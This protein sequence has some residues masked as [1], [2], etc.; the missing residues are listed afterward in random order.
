MKK[1]QKFEFQCYQLQAGLI[2]GSSQQNKKLKTSLSGD[3]V[4]YECNSKYEDQA[5]K[6]KLIIRFNHILQIIHGRLSL[7]DPFKLT[8]KLDGASM[9]LKN[10]S[11]IHEEFYFD[12]GEELETFLK[13]MHYIHEQKACQFPK[14]EQQEVMEY[15]RRGQ[16]FVMQ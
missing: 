12:N 3:I 14:D 4:V 2:K 10:F 16:V 11:E 5:H 7:Q 1:G 13:I 6:P 15:K 9:N 8:F